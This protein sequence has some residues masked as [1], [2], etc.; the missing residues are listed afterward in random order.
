MNIDLIDRHGISLERC[1]DATWLC[2]FQ[3]RLVSDEKLAVPPYVSNALLLIQDQRF[4]MSSM[5][6]TS[7]P[8]GSFGTV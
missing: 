7:T 5:R 1:E 3:T 6:L 2:S 4:R 8:M